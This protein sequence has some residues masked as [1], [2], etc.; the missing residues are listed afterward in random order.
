MKAKILPLI[1]VG[2]LALAGC[3]KVD[4]SYK[5][6]TSADV[7]IFIRNLGNSYLRDVDDDGIVDGI[8]NNLQFNDPKIL[9]YFA[10]GYEDDRRLG[11]IRWLAKEM[12][13][14]MRATASKVH[15]GIN[16]LEKELEE[17]QK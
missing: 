5:K 16:E 12:T 6:N 9:R 17:N 2:S 10:K 14:E 13:P 8:S 1:L 7:N 3:G 15:Q 4:N 11:E